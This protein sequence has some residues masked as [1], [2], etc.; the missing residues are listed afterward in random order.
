MHSGCVQ[1][2]PAANL[3]LAS[4]PLLATTDATD[5]VRVHIMD[6]CLLLAALLVVVLRYFAL[7]IRLNWMLLQPADDA[8]GSAIAFGAW[9]CEWDVR[10]KLAAP[11]NA[12]VEAT[13]K[14]GKLL[15]L[16]VTPPSR[17]SFV[18]VQPCQIIL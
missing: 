10:F 18:H 15:S 17:A 16:V 1:T 12:T 4:V 3:C 2:L 5:H 14:G 13:F 11:H 8:D 7:V 9:P 6:V